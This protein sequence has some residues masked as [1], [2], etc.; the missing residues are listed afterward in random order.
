TDCDRSILR[1]YRE[2]VERRLHCLQNQ[3]LVVLN[4]PSSTS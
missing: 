1:Q 3:G 2:A 4:E